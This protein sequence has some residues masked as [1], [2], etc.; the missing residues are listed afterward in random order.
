MFK[1][2]YL[3]NYNRIVFYKEKILNNKYI[4]LLINYYYFIIIILLV[5]ALV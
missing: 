4:T 3:L 1:N 5:A 2:C